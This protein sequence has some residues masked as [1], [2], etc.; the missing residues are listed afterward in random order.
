MSGWHGVL[1]TRER[2]YFSLLNLQS[3]P[4]NMATKEVAKCLHYRGVRII[5][6]GIV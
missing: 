5:G 1:S 3:S 2:C 6:V 4:L